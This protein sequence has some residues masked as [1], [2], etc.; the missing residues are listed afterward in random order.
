[1]PHIVPQRQIIARVDLPRFIGIHNE[2]NSVSFTFIGNARYHVMPGLKVR[3]IV[4]RRIEAEIHLKQVLVSKYPKKNQ[5]HTQLTPY[6]VLDGDFC[7]PITH[8]AT[9]VPMS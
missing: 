3:R 8:C 2:G 5:Y 6:N 9:P 4:V 7:L 1:M